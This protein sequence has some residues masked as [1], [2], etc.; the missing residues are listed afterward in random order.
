MSQKTKAEFPVTKFQSLFNSSPGFAH[1]IISLN[2]DDDIKKPE[3]FC[4]RSRILNLFLPPLKF[5]FALCLSPFYL[6]VTTKTCKWETQPTV[7]AKSWFP[8]KVICL[9]LTIFDLFWMIHFVRESLPKDAKNPAHHIEMIINVISQLFKCVMIKK[10]WLNKND[11]VKIA[12]F[13]LNSEIPI[14]KTKWFI[15]GGNVF[16]WILLIIY[17]TLGISYM[18]WLTGDVDDTNLEVRD[19]YDL[20]K[21]WHTMVANGRYNFF[22]INSTNLWTPETTQDSRTT[23]LDVV[24]GILST[25]GLL[26]R[27]VLVKPFHLQRYFVISFKTQMEQNFAGVRFSCCRR[28]FGIHCDGYLMTMAVLTLWIPSKAFALSLNIPEDDADIE[29]SSFGKTSL[30]WEKIE[31]EFS[32]LKRLS[33]LVNKV[34]GTIV[35]LFLLEALLCYGATV[36]DLI[37]QQDHPHWKTLVADVIYIVHC[38]CIILFAAD[39]C[40]Q[41]SMFQI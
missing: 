7:V 15:K 36:V 1:A 3:D 30:V 24:I 34:F 28:M 20:S 33:C 35:I 21:W 4:V 23:W 5:T 6:R 22:L 8:Q 13:I 41:V 11:F 9:L 39:I 26:H 2:E 27:L 25:V 19:Q 12:N 18:D 38:H 10:L 32:A 29:S 14:L 37:M 40:Y 31:R 17:T 16:I